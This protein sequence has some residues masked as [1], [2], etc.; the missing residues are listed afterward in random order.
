LRTLEDNLKTSTFYQRDFKESWC[1]NRFQ[2]FANL[3]QFE[4]FASNNMTYVFSA[5][6][7]LYKEP[8]KK[9]EWKLLTGRDVIQH[10]LV[11]VINNLL[12]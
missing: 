10:S 8:S 3:K 5:G 12:A 4:Q 1:N 2:K 11:T 7:W 6:H 9:S